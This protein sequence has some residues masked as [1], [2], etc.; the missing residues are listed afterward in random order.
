MPKV[1]GLQSQVKVIRFFLDKYFF[2]TIPLFDEVHESMSES[3][4]YL[5][6]EQCMFIVPVVS[7][8]YVEEKS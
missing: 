3:S 7:Y 4:I 6:I 5:Y 1:F 2:P 8:W